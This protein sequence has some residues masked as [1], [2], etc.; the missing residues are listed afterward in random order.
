VCGEIILIYPSATMERREG[1]R[2]RRL[3]EQQQLRLQKSDA[4][5]KKGP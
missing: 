4:I 2:E 5:L 1:A 3:L